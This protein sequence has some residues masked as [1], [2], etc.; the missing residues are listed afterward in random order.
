MRHDFRLFWLGQTSSIFG[1]LFTTTATGLVAVRFLGATPA[2]TGLLVAAASVTPLLLGVPIGALADRLDR[3]RRVLIGCDLSGMAAVGLLAAALWLHWASVWWLLGLNIVLGGVTLIV[4][5]VY[6]LHLRGI[7]ARNELVVARARLQTGEYGAGV[8]GRALAGPVVAAAGAA[9]AFGIDALSYLVSAVSL[10]RLRTPEQRRP[11]GHRTEPRSGGMLAGLR[12]LAGHGFLRP[13]AGY[14]A[15]QGLAAGAS[16]ALTAQFLIRVLRLPTAIYGLPF[17]LVGVCGVIGSL[18]AARLARRGTAAR[19]MTAGGFIAGAVAAAMLPLARGPVALAVVLAGLGIAL[20]VFFGAIANVGMTS[21]LTTEVPEDVLG[22]AIAGMQTLMTFVQ[23][24]G[25]VGGGV[26]GGV[27]GVRPAL[28]LATGVSLAGLTLAVPMVRAS[29]SAPQPAGP[30][31]A[32]P[33]PAES[34]EVDKVDEVDE[35]DA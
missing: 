7:V 8:V 9:T 19:T 32:G 27:L 11:G 2:Q 29:R 1:S 21:T 6:F 12:L 22:R 17:M 10:A 25:A 35:V 28:W 20:P 13:V 34:I 18:A 15:V 4:E 3:P 5:T 31:P 26:I 30:Q 24:A 16:S 33:E 23:L 14:L